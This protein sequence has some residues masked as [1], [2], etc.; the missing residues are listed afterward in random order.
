ML[1]G[2]TKLTAL[3]WQPAGS[4]HHP[5][6]LVAQLPST[7]SAVPELFVN[8]SRQV[9]AR[10]PNANPEKQYFPTGYGNCTW[11]GG[12][13]TPTACGACGASS[14]CNMQGIPKGKHVDIASPTRIKDSGNAKNGNDGREAFDKFRFMTGGASAIW[15][16]SSLGPG[17]RAAAGAGGAFSFDDDQDYTHNVRAGLTV[18]PKDVEKVRPWAAELGPVWVHSYNDGE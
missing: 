4:T 18:A 11:S 8:G 14:H 15:A 5:G 7:V 13:C 10:Y 9:L 3:H 2:G 1:S 12:V 16:E 6:V 17:T